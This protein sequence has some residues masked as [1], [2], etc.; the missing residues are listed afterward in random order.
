M[1][2]KTVVLESV[3]TRGTL[4]IEEVEVYL[5]SAK[6]DFKVPTV[7]AW[8]QTNTLEVKIRGSKSI[9]S[10][11]SL[12]AVKQISDDSDNLLAEICIR[13]FS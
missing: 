10:V 12:P 9:S 13:E 3:D 6:L 5:N 8:N 1:S 11:S 7:A 2:D 4:Q